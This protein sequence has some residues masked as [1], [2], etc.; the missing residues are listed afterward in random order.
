M[1]YLALTVMSFV[2]PIAACGGRVTDDGNNPNADG[3]VEAS[4]DVGRDPDTEL[5]A[6]EVPPNAPCAPVLGHN[7]CG[8]KCDASCAAGEECLGFFDSENK[9]RFD[10]GVCVKSSQPNPFVGD[11]AQHCNV[12]NNDSDL[13]VFTDALTLVCVP[14]TLCQRF[15]PKG[16]VSVASPCLYQDKARWNT[17][18]VIASPPCPADAGKL[19]LC[20][21]SC[22]GCAPDETCTGRSPVHPVRGLRRAQDRVAGR[23]V[24][25][26]V[27]GGRRELPRSASMCHGHRRLGRRAEMGGRAGVLY[28]LRAL[29]AVGEDLPRQV[30]VPV[31]NGMATKSNSHRRSR[32]RPSRPEAEMEWSLFCWHRRRLT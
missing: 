18:D 2:L 12:C 28:R 1:K 15:T 9:G 7:A 13:C 31:R 30:Q 11:D 20:G 32:S 4:A 6:A 22:G 10:P 21:G 8:G 17:G 24:V 16:S 29:R 5:D 27:R 3:D 14:A 26:Q 25:Q 23:T 19:G